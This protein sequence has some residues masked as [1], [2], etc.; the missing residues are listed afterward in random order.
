[1]SDENKTN[2]ESISEEQI[3]ADLQEIKA[4][5]KQER[6]LFQIQSMK[7]LVAYV[8]SLITIVSTIITFAV[9]F[10]TSHLE[11]KIEKMKFDYD[12]EMKK[13]K[14]MYESKIKAYSDYENKSKE[15]VSEIVFLKYSISYANAVNKYMK[16]ET[17]QNAY[18]LKTAI[19]NFAHYIYSKHKE[20]I[21]RETDID[22]KHYKNL[23]SPNIIL[24]GNIYPVPD[25]IL[26]KVEEIKRSK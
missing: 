11:S 20:Q 18:E 5:V 1:M 22:M 3:E 24:N 4:A 23:T 15:F 6:P 10:Q 17:Q 8:T 13:T 26:M 12:T 25:D 16:K 9:S 7:A 2:I 21:D 14:E 19:D